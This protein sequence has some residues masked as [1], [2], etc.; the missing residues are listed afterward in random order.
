MAEAAAMTVS[1]S[2]IGDYFTG[3]KRD[4][5]AALQVTVASTSAFVFNL[6]GGVLGAYGWRAPFVAYALPLLL[7]PLVQIFIWDTQGGRDLREA[8]A[9]AAD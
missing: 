5:Y 6:M 2:F 8:H 1:T 3:A 7:A 4:R 9:H